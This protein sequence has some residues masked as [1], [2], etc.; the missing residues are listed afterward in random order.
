[1][2][3]ITTFGYFSIVQKNSDRGAGTLTVRSRLRKDL[4]LL[5]ARYLPAMGPIE[6]RGGADYPYRA[7]AKREDL[8]EA[9]R[10]SI[11]DLTYSN[12]KAEVALELG[13]KREDAYTEVWMALRKLQAL[14][15]PSPQ[16]DPPPVMNV[17]AAGR[18]G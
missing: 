7:K 15:D 13:H 12:F 9:F 2:W 4:D 1:M 5:K 18:R 3:L 6:A 11:L 16:P 17:A 8:A 10:K 14:D